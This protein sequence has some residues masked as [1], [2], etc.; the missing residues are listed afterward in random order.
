M[1]HKVV[2]TSQPHDYNIHIYFPDGELGP[3]LGVT[4]NRTIDISRNSMAN[5]VLSELKYDKS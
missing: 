3:V 2:K 1:D 4:M 5:R